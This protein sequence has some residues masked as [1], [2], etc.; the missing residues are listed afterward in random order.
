MV[1]SACVAAYM[2]H[3]LGNLVT[4][5]VPSLIAGSAMGAF[6]SGQLAVIVPEEP[7]QYLF[8]LVIF[9]MGSHK[10]WSLR[11]LV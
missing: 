11:G 8:T 10:L 9:G 1:P 2:H 4:C 3:R 7:L 6:A 5:A